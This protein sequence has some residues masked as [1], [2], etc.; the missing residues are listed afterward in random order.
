M[1]K[2]FLCDQ[3]IPY[4]QKFVHSIWNI[5]I[6]HQQRFNNRK[7]SILSQ[8]VILLLLVS[9][10]LLFSD[11]IPSKKSHQR[12]WNLGFSKVQSRFLDSNDEEKSDG[13]LCHRRNEEKHVEEASSDVT[14]SLVYQASTKLLEL[15]EPNHIIL[16]SNQGK[17]GELFLG[18]NASGTTPSHQGDNEESFRSQ[19]NQL[20]FPSNQWTTGELFLGLKAAGKNPSH[21]GYNEE[22]FRL[23]PNQN[24]SS[25][26]GTTEELFP[27]LKGSGT[28]PS[29]QGENEEI[30]EPTKTSL[31]LDRRISFNGTMIHNSASHGMTRPNLSILT[32]AAWKISC[33]CAAKLEPYSDDLLMIFHSILDQPPLS[34]KPPKWSKQLWKI[35]WTWRTSDY[36]IVEFNAALYLHRRIFQYRPESQLNFSTGIYYLCP[37][38]FDIDGHL[39]FPKSRR[40]ENMAI[41]SFSTAF[42]TDLVLLALLA[43]TL[44]IIASTFD[45]QLKDELRDLV[46][47]LTLLLYEA[48]TQLL[49]SLVSCAVQ[50]LFPLARIFR[51]SESV[52]L[53]Y[54]STYRSV[55]RSIWL[56]LEDLEGGTCQRCGKR[57]CPMCLLDEET[58]QLC[59]SCA[60]DNE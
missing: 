34:D 3:K 46:L 40:G 15:Q 28:T 4:L 38:P 44:T 52:H 50:D 51:K 9:A 55:T 10:V 12:R 57:V 7:P 18:W 49:D 54:P 43:A 30:I 22:S 37:L 58:G 60:A 45:T 35:P 47:H 27:G 1:K 56:D 2:G 32:T 33:A 8:V 53:Y 41:N 25:N 14:P 42:D 19:A 13:H 21:Q 24:F 5:P 39:D 16:P 11:G 6:D 23:K 17:T 36:S 29:H 20:I 48:S 26:Q 59:S 31:E